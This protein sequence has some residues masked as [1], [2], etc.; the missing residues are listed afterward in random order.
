MTDDDLLDFLGRVAEH[1]FHNNS[2]AALDLLYDEIE[3]L[4][5]NLDYI[6]G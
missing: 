5:G 2:S 3:N 4:G 6:I 1:V